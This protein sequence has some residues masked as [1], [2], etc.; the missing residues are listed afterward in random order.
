MFFS[1][2]RPVWKTRIMPDELM[3]ENSGPL[4]ALRVFQQN[5]FRVI[6]SEMVVATDILSMNRHA[7]AETESRR[8]YL[9]RNELILRHN[10]NL[11]LPAIK[12]DPAGDLHILPL[13]KL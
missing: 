3:R 11:R 6:D 2:N 10:F 7:T 8:I 4:S 9:L 1:L 13:E 12:L 5:A